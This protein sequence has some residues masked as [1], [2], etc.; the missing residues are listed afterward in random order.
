VSKTCS[1]RVSVQKRLEFSWKN[2][3]VSLEV[4]ETTTVEGILKKPFVRIW[5]GMSRLSVFSSY[6]LL[7]QVTT[8]RIL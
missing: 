8:L 3:L 2:L 7:E 4:L 1:F 5:I 6:E